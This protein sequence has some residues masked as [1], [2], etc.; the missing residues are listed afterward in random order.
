MTLPHQI[1]WH[2]QWHQHPVVRNTVHIDQILKDN[3]A[4]CR[5]PVTLDGSLLP[6]DVI[7]PYIF[8]YLTSAWETAMNTWQ[9]DS[10]IEVFNIEVVFNGGPKGSDFFPFHVVFKFFP[11]LRV[12]H[13]FCRILDPPL[14]NLLLVGLWWT[15]TDHSRCWLSIIHRGRSRI[16]RRVHQPLS[17]GQEL[18]I[19]QEFLLQTACKLKKWDRGS[20]NDGLY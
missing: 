6:Q 14:L 19:W 4:L 20:A 16:S 15:T 8:V 18:V 2:H 3:L 7:Y 13:L 1:H 9:N 10:V 17:V 5:E 12:W 11:L